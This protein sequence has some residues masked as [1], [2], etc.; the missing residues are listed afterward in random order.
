MDG[1]GVYIKR[2]RYDTVVLVNSTLPDLI[3]QNQFSFFFRPW[4]EGTF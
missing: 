3:C 1:G 2:V 4:K